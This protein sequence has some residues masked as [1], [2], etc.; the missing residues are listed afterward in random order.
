MLYFLQNQ[1]TIARSG[2]AN[3][4]RVSLYLTPT[5]PSAGFFDNLNLMRLPGSI[6]KQREFCQ[7]GMSFEK[8]GGG[9]LC[10]TSDTF[11]FKSPMSK[12]FRSP[13]PPDER[14][15]RAGQPH[16]AGPPP[17]TDASEKRKRRKSAAIQKVPTWNVASNASNRRAFRAWQ[18]YSCRTGF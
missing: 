17:A 13:F 5:V 3:G 4:S 10:F 7:V 14:C 16:L 2:L 12:D 11:F 6:S 15:A 9:S 1:A 18:N 8:R